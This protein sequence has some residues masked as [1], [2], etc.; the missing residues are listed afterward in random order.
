MFRRIIFLSLSVFLSS[1]ILAKG[2]QVDLLKKGTEFDQLE[3]KLSDK[4]LV[5][6]L[7]N[8]TQVLEEADAQKIKHAWLTKKT[9][10]NAFDLYQQERNERIELSNQLAQLRNYVDFQQTVGVDNIINAIQVK[11]QA[12]QANFYLP[13]Y[14]YSALE[15]PFVEESERSTLLKVQRAAF[16]TANYGLEQVFSQQ[17]ITQGEMVKNLTRITNSGR[18]ELETS[19]NKCV[20]NNLEKSTTLTLEL[21]KHS[22]YPFA[23]DNRSHLQGTF[24]RQG[25]KQPTE[26]K[27]VS[28]PL[29]QS[30][31][32]KQ[33][34]KHCDEAFIEQLTNQQLVSDLAP[35]KQQLSLLAKQL[36]QQHAILAGS[37]RQIF[38]SSY[39]NQC[40][41]LACVANNLNQ[42]LE[43]PDTWPKVVIL[44]A[45]TFNSSVE[46]GL[47]IALNFE[48]S[49]K[50]KNHLQTIRTSVTDEMN[51][52]VY[53]LDKSQQLELAR[54]SHL[55]LVPFAAH[56]KVGVIARLELVAPNSELP[57]KKVNIGNHTLVFREVYLNDQPHW[58][59]ENSLDNQ[60]LNYFLAENKQYHQHLTTQSCARRKDF[61]N[62]LTPRGLEW[63]L[64][65]I[66][67]QGAAEQFS[68]PD[69]RAWDSHLESLDASSC[70]STKGQLQGLCD[71]VRDVCQAGGNSFFAIGHCDTCGGAPRINTKAES[72]QID[73]KNGLRL[74][75][76]SH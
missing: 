28:L 35:K 38:A 63:F 17:E 59:A 12:E 14:L 7:L 67:E 55:T 51:S 70:R 56:G 45:D 61:A 76:I 31:L 21:S 50:I 24:V 64:R 8:N 40:N 3:K 73:P 69:C 53:R 75:L 4:H 9:G 20:I 57:Q 52:G 37:V 65:W 43:V 44:Q 22:F 30:I 10:N 5:K 27:I 25:N 74:Q 71:G 6:D 2:Y 18:L 39:A 19:I 41:S 47:F 13:I 62:C 36:S 26:A 54:I 68:L 1:P 66:N 72:Y 49:E 34:L 58:I 48:L 60:F 33:P 11:L 32:K 16:V 15:L 42:P 23:P 46:M 29:A